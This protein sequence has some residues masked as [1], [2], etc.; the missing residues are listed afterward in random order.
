MRSPIIFLAVV[1]FAA[2]ASLQAAS[3]PKPS[4]KQTVKQQASGKKQQQPVKVYKS[5]LQIARERA[6]K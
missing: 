4:S 3:A 6:A 2:S 1:L 5:N